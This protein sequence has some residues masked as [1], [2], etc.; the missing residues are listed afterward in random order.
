MSSDDKIKTEVIGIDDLKEDEANEN[1]GT[2]RG[3]AML[4]A[5]I[6]AYGAGPSGTADKNRRLIAGNKTRDQMKAAGVTEVIVVSAR[7]DQWVVVQREDLD[8]KKDARARGLARMANR[9][10]QVN[11]E[12]DYERLAAAR[13]AGEDLSIGW[14]DEEL[15][16]IEAQAQLMAAL[17]AGLAEELE[18]GTAERNLAGQSRIVKAVL[19]M[20]D[21]PLFEQAILATGLSN[22]A[23]AIAEIC[24]FYLGPEGGDPMAELMAEFGESGES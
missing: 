13:A 9:A 16:E 2:P 15:A 21:A 8:L 19:Y 10:G 22:R 20:E 24:R 11:F 4:R 3:A 23:E 14:D 5:S 12:L 7:P 1:I 18:E 6:E 17:E